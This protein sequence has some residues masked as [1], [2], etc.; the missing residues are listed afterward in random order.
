MRAL[1]AEN[2]LNALRNL[3]RTGEVVRLLR[4]AGIQSIVLK[5]PL[6]AHDLYGDVALRVAGDVDVLVRDSELLGAAQ[7]LVAARYRP[8]TPVTAAAIAKYRKRSHDLSFAHPD[9][10]TLVELHADIAQPHYG[11]HINFEEC[12][13]ARR[14][15]ALG[16]ETIWSPG[17]PDAHLMTALHAAKHRWHRLDL[18]SDIAA[19]GALGI[20]PGAHSWMLKP[21][22]AGQRIVAWL[23]EGNRSDSAVVSRA[24]RQLATGEEFGRLEGMGFDLALRRGVGEKAKYLWKRIVSAKLEV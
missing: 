13:A 14:S 18:V 23:F 16:N 12:W 9:D 11:Y 1:S 8:D 10:D 5:G 17:L 6:L 2:A 4:L 15:R 22:D 19:F 24:V 21:L 3:A 20:D 7:T